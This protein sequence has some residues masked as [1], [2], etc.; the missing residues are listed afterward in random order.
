[1]L[2]EA[3]EEQNSSNKSIEVLEVSLSSRFYAVLR[4]YFIQIKRKRYL[5][6]EEIYIVDTVLDNQVD[7]IN[8]KVLLKKFAAGK[9]NK[10]HK[11]ELFE[12]VSKQETQNNKSYT[13]TSLKYKK[14]EGIYLYDVDVETFLEIWREA[15]LGYNKSQLNEYKKVFQAN[16]TF[17]KFNDNKIENIEYFTSGIFDSSDDFMKT[18]ESELNSN[19]YDENKMKETLKNRKNK[20]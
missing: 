3:I 10:S 19:T 1:M 7:L 5:T 17:S 20:N 18:I 9:F 16:S 15:T 6:K 2:N 14:A 11:N 13:I 4:L 12:L 8:L